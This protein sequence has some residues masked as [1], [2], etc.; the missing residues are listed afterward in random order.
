M[1]NTDKTN[2]YPFTADQIA[3]LR[4]DELLSWAKVA[5]RLNGLGSPGAAR[6]AYTALVR[7]HTESVLPGRTTGGAGLTPIALG[8]LDL[9]A[10]REAIV[11]KTVVV[12]R[13]GDKTEAIPV[14]KV[15]SLKD[16]T[17]NFNDG[18]K[19]RSAKADAI[20]ATKG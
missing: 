20:I 9:A 8:D 13:Q 15:T 5:Q 10:V 6:R 11:G 17:V 12:Q 16:G 14:A 2:K 18:N 19:A 3:A 4:D 1:T 7:P